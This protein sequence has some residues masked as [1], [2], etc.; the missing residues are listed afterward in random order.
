MSKRILFIACGLI[1][2]YAAVYFGDQLRQFSYATEVPIFVAG[3]WVLFIV[4]A[5]FAGTTWFLVIREVVEFGD[6]YRDDDDIAPLAACSV[7]LVA[8]A[9]GFL[10]SPFTTHGSYPWQWAS[11]WAIGLVVALVPSAFVVLGVVLDILDERRENKRMKI[12]EQPDNVTRLPRRD[13]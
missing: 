11:M 10:A 5:Y 1:V 2:A 12:P 6:W 7:S 9:F 4:A 8:L 3:C 13:K